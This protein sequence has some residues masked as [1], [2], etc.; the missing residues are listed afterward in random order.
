M[1]RERIYEFGRLARFF[2]WM[3]CVNYGIL[4]LSKTEST[5]GVLMKGCLIC[6]MSGV[7]IYV[8]EVFMSATQ[9][10][11]H[12]PVVY[13][14]LIF[15]ALHFTRMFIHIP[16]GGYIQGNIWVSALPLPLEKLSYFFLFLGVY[17]ISQS[18]GRGCISEISERQIDILN[19]IYN[20]IIYIMF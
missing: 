15:S 13:G 6:R 20:L 3:R 5:P 1:E 17:I 16:L 11:C 9:V 7:N 12:I 14:F 2:C 4:M 19:Y 8:Y 10:V 18:L